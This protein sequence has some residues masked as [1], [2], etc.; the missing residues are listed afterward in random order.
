MRIFV[1]ILLLITNVLNFVR[2]QAQNKYEFT[3]LQCVAYAK[4]HNVDVKNAL[5]SLKIQEQTNRAITSAALPNLIGNGNVI[6]NIRVPTQ[7]LPGDFLGQPPGTFIPVRF[8]IKYTASGGLTLN[9][10]LFDGQVFVGLQA[11]RASLEFQ[12][13]NI[14]VTEEVIKKNIYKIYYQ[15]V[16]SRKQIELLDANLDRLNKLQYDTREI[17]K[18]GFAEKIDVDKL[19][20]QLANLQTQK[21]GVVSD[22]DK[23]YLGL[24]LLMGMP[25]KDS[26]ILTDSIS[27]AKLKDGLLDD[28]KY[29]YNNRKEYQYLSIASRLREYN[30]RRYKLSYIPTLSFSA[31]YT[32]TAQRPTFDFTHRSGVWFPSAYISLHLNV[33]LFDGFAGAAHL[34]QARLELQ[35]SRNTLDNLKLSIDNDVEQ[36]KLSYTTAIHTIDFQKKNM[37]LAEQVYYQTKKKYEIGT[38]SNTE[39]TAAQTELV[40]AQT[41]YI[42]ALYDAI[43]ARIDYLAAIGKL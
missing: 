20:V 26:L 37:S 34:Q 33:P 29:Q 12:Q 17:Y 27:E 43:I 38:G 28:G 13:K 40:Q 23:G 9:Q 42:N 1:Y 22:I 10:T 11:R 3:V 36:S 7:L 19:E 4:Q 15:L 5:L 2:V 30:V 21:S 24:K 18:N 8:G 16:V 41:N 35:Q 32:Y 6:D 25:L 14:E 31:N 39:I